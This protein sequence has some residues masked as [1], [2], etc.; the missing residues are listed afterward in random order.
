M[1]I[2]NATTAAEDD[3]SIDHDRMMVVQSRVKEVQS[4]K[5]ACLCCLI[6]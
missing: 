1:C 2:A 3:R 6:I 5:G 4:K